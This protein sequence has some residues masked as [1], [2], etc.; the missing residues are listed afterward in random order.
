MSSVEAFPELP[1]G[2]I[3][4]A[5]PTRSWGRGPSDV[6]R[7]AMY[8]NEL[9]RRQVATLIACAGQPVSRPHTELWAQWRNQQREVAHA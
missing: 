5:R 1:D 8:W 7:G 9:V 3:K 4:V 2:E 6:E